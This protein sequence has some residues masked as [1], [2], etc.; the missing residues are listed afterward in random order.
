MIRKNITYLL[1]TALLLATMAGFAQRKKSSNTNSSSTALVDS[2][3]SGIKLRNIGP[4]LMS[5]RIADVAIHPENESIWYVAVGSGGVWK[6]ENAGTT[7]TPVFDDQSSYSIG[8]VSIDPNNPHTIWVG[9]G[10]NVGGRHVGFGD[11]VY[12]S[13]DGGASWENMGLKTSE[14]ISKVIVHPTNS[15]IVWVASQ[16]PL[17][18]SGG[19]RGVYKTA[20]GG[21]TW[22]KTLGDALW[23][24]ATD[25]LIDP[26]NPDVLYAATWDRHRTVAAYMGGGP[27][28]GIHKSTDGGETWSELTDGLPTSNMGK[29][30]LAISPQNPD[31]VYA[32]IELD[33]RTGGVYRSADKGM[34]WEKRSDAVS[35]ATGPHYYQELYASPHEFEKL[36]LV[37]VRLQVSEDGGKNFHLINYEHKH[38]DNHAI[39][40]KKSD[41]NYIL[42]GTDGGIYESFDNMKNWRFIKNLPVT[43]FYKVAVDDSEPFYNV[44]GGTQD[45]S[46]QGGPSRTD[47]V[48]GI[49]NGDWEIVLDWDGHQPATEPGNPNIMY[50]ERQ[51]GNISRIDLKTGEVIDIQPQPDKDEPHERF[52]WDA[53][54]LVSP[55]SPS[56][57]YFASYRVWKSEN[58]GDKWT[59][60]SG[61]LTKNQNRIELPIMGRKQSWDNAWDFLAMSNYNTI[62]SLA[63]SPKKAGVIYAGTDDGL[64]QVTENGGESW[65]KIE[66][67]NLPGVPSTAFVNDIKADLFDENTVYVALDNHKYGD[68]KPYLLKSTDKGRTWTSITGNL[69]SK[70]LVWRM[71][72]DHVNPQ[73]LFA[74]TEYGIYFTI[75]GGKNWVKVAGAPTISFR[76]LAIQR[77]ENDLIGASFGRGFFV[78]DDYSVLREVTEAKLQQEAALYS[79]RK[80]WWYIPRSDIS[81]D[82]PKG[83]LGAAHYVAPNPEFGA[84]FTY[85]LKEEL[86]SKKDAR[87]ES[88]KKAEK[89]KSNISFPGY[90]NVLAEEN[91]L[92][93]QIWLTVEDSNGKVIRRIKG[94]TTLG[95]HRIAWDLRHP[96]PEAI[97]LGQDPSED[98]PAGMLAAPGKYKVSLSKVVDG[99]TTQLAEPVEFDVVPLREGTL[100][101]ASPEVV[102]DFMRNYETVYGRKT[103]VD[104]RL[105]NLTSRS[106]AV[107]KSIANSNTKP[108]EL[109]TRYN[110]IRSNIQSL[111]TQVNGNKAKLQ[112]G[113]KTKPNLGERIFALYRG[114]SN[115]TY[116]PTET[117]KNT[118]A[119]ITEELDSVEGNLK[120]LEAELSALVKDLQK[121]GAP[122]VEG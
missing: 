122:W 76:D 50:G 10:E 32:A 113:E 102:A 14:H 68:F 101:G 86:K 66:L 5:G 31:I 61:D 69:P 6:T 43:Q 41:P 99:K 36:Y 92:E 95:F 46:T 93:P 2:V 54:I 44:Y 37:D 27:G 56:T 3:F 48:Q 73:L 77:R 72:Q 35:G 110:T 34:T 13:K 116:G 39:A 33:R 26:R 24:G 90:E 83:S 104:I 22:K 96:L 25:L 119:I 51:E 94:N 65:R 29:I 62:T 60:I 98:E 59:A 115:S 114:L 71:V 87:Q 17:W 15:D 11:G 107:A 45:N 91:Q 53:P 103:A 79:T 78:L 1:T 9:T 20:D 80:A 23:T 47:N 7:W 112:I 70:T 21:K 84:V 97:A 16:G 109:D 40:F 30:G 28:S 74:G 18:K 8:C 64:I 89:S 108:G 67:T 105:E 88:E 4:A 12:R 63:E 111:E 42:V 55:H 85:Y 120:S 81:F 100:K 75:N 38:S 118:M 106:N 121:A 52:N 82:E 49:Q 19:E 58:R 57:I 117:H